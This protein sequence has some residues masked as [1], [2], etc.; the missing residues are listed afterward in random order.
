MHS[1]PEESEITLFIHVHIPSML[2]FAFSEWM[3]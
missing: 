3:P 1:T 2:P